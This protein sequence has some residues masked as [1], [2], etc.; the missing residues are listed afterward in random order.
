MRV[1]AQDFGHFVG[2]RDS[3]FFPIFWQEP[4]LGFCPDVDAPMR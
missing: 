4:V 2:E 3:A 1:L